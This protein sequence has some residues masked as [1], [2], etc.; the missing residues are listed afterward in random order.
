V[1]VESICYDEQIIN[2]NILATKLR[3]PDYVAMGP[4]DAVPTLLYVLLCA[5]HG[6][7]TDSTYD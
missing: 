3:S 6:Y 4:D 7:H 5:H 2:N 1:F